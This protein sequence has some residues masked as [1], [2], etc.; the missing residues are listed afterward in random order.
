MGVVVGG[1]AGPPGAGLGAMIGFLNGFMSET[2]QV[3]RADSDSKEDDHA[4]KAK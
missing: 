2:R 1:L 3:G 4:A